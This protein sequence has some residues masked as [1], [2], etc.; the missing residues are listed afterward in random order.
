MQTRRK[1]KYMEPDFGR[2]VRV[3]INAIDDVSSN[4]CN[5][6]DG[7]SSYLRTKYFS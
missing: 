1:S 2:M 3:G 5:R 6:N 4:N 7:L